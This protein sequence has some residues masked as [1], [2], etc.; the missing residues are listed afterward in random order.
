MSVVGVIGTIV[1]FAV[2][3]LALMA[4]LDVIFSPSRRSS[5]EVRATTPQST[6]LASRLAKIFIRGKKHGAR[7]QESHPG[8]GE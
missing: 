3:A 5:G 6:W 8:R 1:F 4:V 7:R 2:V